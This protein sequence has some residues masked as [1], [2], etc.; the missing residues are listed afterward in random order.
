MPWL[1]WR[2]VGPTDAVV[3]AYFLNQPLGDFAHEARDLVARLGAIQP[4]GFCVADHQLAH[5]AGDADIGQTAFFFEAAGFFQAHLVREQAFFH[6]DQEHQRELQP[7]GAVQ[8]HQLHAVFVLG[9][10]GVAGF[11]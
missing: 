11:Q 2:A 4:A 9:G 6:A 8:G 1:T 3:Q 7:L 10:L 5:G